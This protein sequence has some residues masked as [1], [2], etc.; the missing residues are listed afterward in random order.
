MKNELN[1]LRKAWER[2]EQAEF[3]GWDFSHIKGRWEEEE[4]PWDYK[5]IVKE[6]LEETDTLLDMGTG[7][8]VL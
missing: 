7:G 1:E 3:S 4:L 5:G 6:R 2:E 8:G